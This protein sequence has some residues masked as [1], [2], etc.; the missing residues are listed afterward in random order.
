MITAKR[1]GG[2]AALL[3]VGYFNILK[4]YVNILNIFNCISR[5]VNIYMNILEYV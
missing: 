4:M 5:Y 1:G 3:R 2:Y